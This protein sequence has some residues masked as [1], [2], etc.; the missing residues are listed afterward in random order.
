MAGEREA[1]ER[2]WAPCLPPAP[3]RVL[4]AGTG[5]GHVARLLADLGYDVVGIDLAPGM[6]AEARR[7][8]HGAERAPVFELA[9]ASDPP[10]AEG[11]FDAITARYVLWTLPH[12]E[13]VLGRW[14]RLLRPGGTL[15]VVD[16]TWFPGGNVSEDGDGT[17]TERSAHFARAYD[18]SDSA[19][20]LL[21][22]THIDEFAAAISAARFSE[23][24]TEELPEVVELDRRHGVPP[25]HEVQM[26]YRISARKP[27][28]VAH[29]E[30][31]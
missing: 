10:F 23:V 27:G 25:G 13:L 15:T 18:A 26:K 12:P 14:R 4:D 31:R 24:R 7:A 3:A 28:G 22:A 20:P 2:V 9:D 11:S 21:G 5:S 30:A 29:S 1:W 19:L 8:S 16:G 6:L 17:V